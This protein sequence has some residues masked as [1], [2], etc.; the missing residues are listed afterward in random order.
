MAALTDRHGLPGP[1]NRRELLASAA[2]GVVLSGWRGAAAVADDAAGLASRPGRG[3]DGPGWP[4]FAC[5]DV[6]NL[7]IQGGE[8][9]LEAGSD[10]FPND[11]RPVAFAVDRRFRDGSVIATATRTGSEAG[12]VVRRT[13]HRHYYAAIYRQEE[14]ALVVVRRS[15]RRGRGAGAH[16]RRW[17]SACPSTLT[18]ESAGSAPTRLRATLADAGGASF[19]AAATDGHPSLQ[20][21]RRSGRADAG[22]HAVPERA[23][24][25]AARAG[26]HPPAAVRGAG[27]QRLHREPGGP[28]RG[29]RHPGPV[30]RELQRHPRPDRRQPRR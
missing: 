15:R 12:V 20:A 21:A 18:L 1:E 10:V 22:D 16:A 14:A 28:V 29:R 11:P 17:P 3:A 23:Q 30:D 4:G 9:V 5:V 8:G 2:A 25:G 24:R 19:A 7:R 13:S 6:A 27:G 26:E